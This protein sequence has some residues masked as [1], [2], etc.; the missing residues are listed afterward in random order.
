M[1]M[2][3]VIGTVLCVCSFAGAA[4]FS[5]WQQNLQI[6][7]SGYTQPETLT[8]FPAL[9]VLANGLDG[10]E[11][12]YSQFASSSGG[13]L[14]FSDSTQTNELNYEIEIW[15]T[16]GNSYVWVQVPA[17]S[18]NSYICAY[19]GNTNQTTPP[20]YTTN[21]ATW[22]SGFATVY[23]MNQ[24]SG[25]T[26]YDSTANHNNGGFNS[27]GGYSWT[28]NG[29]A[30]GCVQ[31]P[32]SGANSGITAGGSSISWSVSAW[33]MGLLP[34][35]SQR[36]LYL[37]QNGNDINI[38]GGSSVVECYGGYGQHVSSP[39]VTI[40]PASSSNQWQQLTAVGTGGNTLIY[41]NGVYG[42]TCAT[43]GS[44]STRSIGFD[45]SLWQGGRQWATSLDEFRIESAARS[46]NWVWASYMTMASNSVFSS[47][48][49]APAP[50]LTG[51]VI[52][53]K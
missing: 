30:D 36:T 46:A 24:T 5:S 34:T 53:I 47:Y 23:H 7:F 20:A 12:Q 48:G 26:V 25:G 37:D 11:F 4:N 35:S 27:S 22:S 14:R 38:G 21:G 44:G 42:G 31:F 43:E 8:N 18:S 2:L 10:G 17:L 1:R 15:N 45:S 3:G 28:N 50:A 29:A 19:W 13:D 9:V 6:T 40:T 49:A 32:A 51:P 39:N 33:F 16:N 41:V 52:R